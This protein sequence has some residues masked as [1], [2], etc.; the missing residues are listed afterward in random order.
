M[1]ISTRLLLSSSMS[2][3]TYPFTLSF[4]TSLVALL[5]LWNICSCT[6]H[7]LQ[8]LPLFFNMNRTFNCCSEIPKGLTVSFRR[9]LIQ[10]PVF[11]TPATARF[12]GNSFSS[13]CMGF[14]G[15]IIVFRQLLYIQ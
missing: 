5:I 7:R 13:V 8:A 11:K 10:Y 2:L 12:H 6:S 9:S 1:E 14:S 15:G 3:V 4:S